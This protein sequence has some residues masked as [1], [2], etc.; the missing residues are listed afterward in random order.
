MTCGNTCVGVASDSLSVEI[1]VKDESP[2]NRDSLRAAVWNWRSDG[3]G[4]G[5]LSAKGWVTI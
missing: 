2:T 1:E 3:R 5:V 4:T